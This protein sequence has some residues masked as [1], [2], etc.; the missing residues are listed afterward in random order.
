MIATRDLLKVE[1]VFSLIR[2]LCCLSL[3]ERFL[4]KIRRLHNEQ[5]RKKKPV[6]KMSKNVSHTIS[7]SQPV[8]FYQLL[9]PPET[10]YFHLKVYC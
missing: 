10:E 7:V 3:N 2:T 9:L 4:V 1:N 6:N 5:T 8:I